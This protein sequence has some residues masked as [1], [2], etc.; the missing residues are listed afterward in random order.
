MN[1]KI[2][3]EDLEKAYNMYMEGNTVVDVAKEVGF[4][5][6]TIQHY[7][8]KSWRAER[9]ANAS[10]LARNLSQGKVKALTAIYSNSLKIL[11]KTLRDLAERSTP[12]SIT[13][14]K[15]VGTILENIDKI[16]RLDEGSATDITETVQPK[17]KEELRDELRSIDPFDALNLGEEKDETENKESDDGSTNS[18]LT[19]PTGD[20]SSTH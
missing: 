17:T 16:T 6:S 12:L 9:M 10:E 4:P 13:E 1:K 11:E 14:A 19:L 8:L 18:I 3:K 2:S 20:G 7:V 5:R 15:G